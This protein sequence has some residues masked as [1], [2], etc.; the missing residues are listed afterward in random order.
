MFERA[1]LLQTVDGEDAASRRKRRA[2]IRSDLSDRDASSWSQHRDEYVE[3][4]GTTDI[5]A[6]VLD[7]DGTVVSTADRKKGPSAEMID[8]IA[9]LIDKRLVVAFAT[10]RGGS[11]G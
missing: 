1:D 2:E 9:S 4:L 10:G 6:V 7:Y 3:R 11:I 5:G 8:A